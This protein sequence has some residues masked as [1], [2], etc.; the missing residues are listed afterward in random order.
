MDMN[1]HKACEELLSNVEITLENNIFPINV[2]LSLYAHEFYLFHTYDLFMAFHGKNIQKAHKLFPSNGVR[3]AEN[4][5][6]VLSLLH[7]Y[8]YTQYIPHTYTHIHPSFIMKAT[9]AI[10]AYLVFF[11]IHPKHKYS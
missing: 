4:I 10:K 7:Y 6:F 11:T 2:T 8:V 5:M 3:K 9:L 1:I